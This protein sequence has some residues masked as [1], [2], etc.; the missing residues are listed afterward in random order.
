MKM[1]TKMALHLSK[2][3]GFPPFC[4]SAL[5]SSFLA[6]SSKLL[7]ILS[8]I[9]DR[10]VVL[11]LHGTDSYPGSTRQIISITDLPS[12]LIAS[13][14]EPPPLAVSSGHGARIKR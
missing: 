6:L 4:F 7:I 11:V 13:V 3:H 1:K 5:A 14:P 12:I 8:S 2:T 9:I 10:Q